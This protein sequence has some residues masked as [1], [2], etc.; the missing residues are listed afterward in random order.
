[1][2]ACGLELMSFNHKPCTY[3]LVRPP[4][5]DRRTSLLV[6]LTTSASSGEILTLLV[7][8]IVHL[9]PA[10]ESDLRSDSHSVAELTPWL[11]LAAAVAV[12]GPR[13]SACPC[14]SACSC[15]QRSRP[16]TCWVP[17]R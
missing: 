11:R 9:A 1:M 14:P 2:I 17:T 15:Y 7:Q 4:I 16:G 13:A 10:C 5:L 8:P 12:P 6:Q 3:I